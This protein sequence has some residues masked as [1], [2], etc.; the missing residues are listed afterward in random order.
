MPIVQSMLGAFVFFASAVAEYHT[1]S[2][3]L[4][5]HR[6]SVVEGVVTNFV[7][8]PPGGHGMETFSI[9]G[10]A[11]SYG[12]GWGSTYFNSEWNGTT[13]HDGVHARITYFGANI[14]KVEVR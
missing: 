9:N 11:F 1:A 5:D 10:V 12:S 2:K 13:F 6:C 4:G 8:S 3:L 14:L 7:P